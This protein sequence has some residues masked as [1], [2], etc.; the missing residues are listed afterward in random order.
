MRE[1]SFF[2]RWRTAILGLGREPEIMTDEQWLKRCAARFVE[3]AHVN[4]TIA[5]S[6]AESC[7]E[8]IADFGFE[9]DPE[10]AADCEMSYWGD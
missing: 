3:R 7:F 8:D 6:F 10:G 4:E 5:R 2:Q 9:N 1:P